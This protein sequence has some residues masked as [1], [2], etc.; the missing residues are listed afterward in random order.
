MKGFT[1]YGGAEFIRIESDEPPLEFVAADSGGSDEDD[2]TRH[3][4]MGQQTRHFLVGGDFLTVKVV[5]LCQG[6]HDFLSVRRH[7]ISIFFRN[8]SG[9]DT[10]QRY[11]ARDTTWTEYTS[12]ETN[13][14]KKRQKNSTT[15]LNDN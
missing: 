7:R 8:A 3:G 4:R 13:K 11:T 5:V 9:I 1:W 6:I 14:Q 12:R 10:K 15:E 2:G